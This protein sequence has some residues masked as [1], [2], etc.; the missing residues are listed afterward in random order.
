[1]E[2]ALCGKTSIQAKIDLFPFSPEARKMLQERFGI[3]QNEPLAVCR[4]CLALPGNLAAKALESER[5]EQRRD[6][7]REALRN[8]R[9]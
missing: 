2:C 5:D 9:N 1:M 6:L 7:I 4:E 3:D 8:S